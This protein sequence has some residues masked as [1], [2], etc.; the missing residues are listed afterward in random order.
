[1]CIS[2][3]SYSQVVYC[4]HGGVWSHGAII[5]GCPRSSSIWRVVCH[6][7]LGNEMIIGSRRGSSTSLT[8]E[9][10]CL[11]MSFDGCSDGALLAYEGG[12]YKVVDVNRL[13]LVV[14]VI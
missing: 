6:S 4:R 12:R 11:E 13:A 8:P 14:H 2:F 7:K 1:V 3:A 10:P 9:K 5:M